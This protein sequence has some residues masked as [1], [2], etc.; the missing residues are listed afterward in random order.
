MTYKPAKVEEGVE[1]TELYGGKVIVRF[2]E[3][4]HMYYISTDGG[5]KFVRKGGVTGIIS[6]V[7]KSKVCLKLNIINS[8]LMLL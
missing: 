3:K 1:Y 4:G 6:I 5:E 2:H 7:D 8:C